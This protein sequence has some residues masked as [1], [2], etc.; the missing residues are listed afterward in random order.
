MSVKVRYWR[1]AWVVDVSTKLAGKRERSIKTFG[2]GGKAKEA[3]QAYA[4]EIA[5]QAKTGKFWERR[6]ATFADLWDKFAAHELASP[7]LR[8]STVA[9]YKA[10]GRLYLVPYLGDRLLSE[11]DTE[12]IMDMKTQLQAAAGSK[13]SGKEGSRKPLSPRSVATI[14][15]LGGSVW[16]YGRRI[17]MVDGSPFADVRKPRA[18]KREPYILDAAD[19]AKLRAALNVPYERLLIELTLTTGMRSGEVRGLTWDSIDLEGKRLFIERQANRRGEEAATKTESS[20]RPIPVPAY[21][22]PELKR[23]KLACPITAR[24]LVFPGE[25]N[26]QGERNPI[27]ADILLRSTSCGGRCAGRGSRRC[28]SMTS[29]TWPALS[30]TRRGCR[31]SGRRRSSGTRASAPPSRSTR[32]PCGART[33]TQP[34]KIAALAGPRRVDAKLGKQSGNNRLRRVSGSWRN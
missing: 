12:V 31:S 21:L 5:P 14:L 29:G 6:T 11:I 1:G 4:Q 10:L 30:C 32:T 24:G 8:P 16:R 3:A 20:V 27:D 9:D 33:T 7:D 28:G 25:P 18:A 17:K 23:W 13:A 34:D 26:A 15:I 19:I 22:I 2:A